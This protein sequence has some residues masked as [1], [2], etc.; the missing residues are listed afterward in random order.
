MTRRQFASEGRGFH[1]VGIWHPKAEVNTGSLWRSASLFGAAFTFTVGR[2]YGRRQAS[3]T[4]NVRAGTPLF[5]Y[6]DIDDLI[7]HLPHSCPLVGVEL[8]PR[9][10]PLSAFTHPVRAC[11]LLGAEDHGLPVAVLDRCHQLV[12]VES[13]VPQSMN[14]A[15]A[16]SVLLHDR[17][18]KAARTAA[19][20][21]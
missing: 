11:Y 12:Q 5:H 14:V 20:I 8:D 19:V 3:D 15:C 6:R 4:P 17:Y 2:R 7:E 10:A 16:G 1:A 18:A 21:A 9:A 13:A